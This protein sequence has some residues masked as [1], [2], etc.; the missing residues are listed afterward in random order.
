MFGA[1]KQT[2]GAF[3]GLGSDALN[4]HGRQSQS[5][6]TGD[7]EVIIFVDVDGV[8][9]V[10]TRDPGNN[11]VSFNE[12]NVQLAMKLLDKGGN[13]PCAKRLAEVHKRQLGH[14]EGSTFAKLESCPKLDVSNVCAA[15]LAQLISLS[16]PHCITV[17]SSNWRRPQHVK[18]VRR[19][20]KLVGYHLG[21]N[22][23]FAGRTSMRP[24][25][26]PE[27][28]LVIIGD[29][30]AQHVRAASE[31]GQPRPI[32]V[33]ILDDFYISP[34]KEWNCGGMTVNT[35][36]EAEQYMLTRSG[37]GA[38]VR[39][40]HSYT[41]WTTNTGLLVQ[42]GTGLTLEHQCN[43]LQFLG[44][45]C[46]F[47][48]GPPECIRPG[49]DIMRMIATTEQNGDAGPPANQREDDSRKRSESSSKRGG[50]RSGGGVIVDLHKDVGDVARGG[51][52]CALPP[53]GSQANGSDKPAVPSSSIMAGGPRLELL[54]KGV[55][56]PSGSFFNV[57]W[58]RLIN[59]SNGPSEAR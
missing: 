42:V 21:R 18:R 7:H 35:V 3:N 13:D 48:G 12:A 9:N 22:F 53:V 36:E 38:Q 8:L 26:T 23:E 25:S 15:R 31:K 17:L 46:S 5:G 51:D 47:C 58:G 50:S 1:M 33:L 11:P 54:K 2:V 43:A 40:I 57:G 6:K 10:G 29:Y 19:L 20:E 24:E 56:P 30:V 4:G 34:I 41:E 59:N 39:L 32:K 52:S 45:R 37:P 44:S 28:R 49:Y 14:G 55:V 16:G 27:Q